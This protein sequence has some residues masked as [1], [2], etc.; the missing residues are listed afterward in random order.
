MLT[1]GFIHDDNIFGNKVPAGNGGATSLSY[2]VR[3]DGKQYFMKQLRPELQDELRNRTLFY[4]EYEIGKARITVDG[5]VVA[6]TVDEYDTATIPCEKD[7]VV[8]IDFTTETAIE[9][10]ATE[11]AKNGAIYDIQGRRVNEVSNNQVYIQDG[12]KRV[13]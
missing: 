2:K 1:S 11:S 10:V 7:A 4:K 3:I 5:K 9:A 12:V 13:K 6:V 8:E